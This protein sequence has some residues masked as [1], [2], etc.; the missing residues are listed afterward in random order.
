MAERLCIFCCHNFQREIAAAIAAE[1]W[2]DVVAV[3][4]PARCGRPPLSW[5]ELRALLPEVGAQVVVLGRACLAGL[6]EAPAGFPPVRLVPFGQCFHMVASAGQVD[7]AIAGGG[8]LITPG[9]L[10]DWRGRLAEMGFPAAASGE[11]FKDF[12]R[13][14]VLFD[15][16]VDP[17]A[18]VKLAELAE[19]VGLPTRR[20]A[21]GL[22]HT[23]L[24]LARL[25]LEWRLDEARR[26]CQ[27]RDR[28]HARELAD[29]VSAMDMLAR[30]ARSQH[31]DEAIAAVEEL[32]HMLFAPAVWHYLRVERDQPVNVAEVPAELLGPLLELATPWAWSPSG[33]GFLL[34]IAR[35]DRVL[36][37][38]A[39]DRLA[40]PE[41]RERYLNL[42]LAMT[43]VCALAIDNARIR[44]R[45]VEAEKM[46]SLAIMVAGV[47]HE[48]NTP[49]GV[50]LAAASTLQEQSR[51][52]DQRFAEHTMTQS[53]L[54]AYLDNTLA[55]A[56]LIRSNMERIGQLI[57]AFRQVA[58]EGHAQEKHRFRLRDCLDE[59]VASLAG[60][61]P[62]DRIAIGVRCDPDLE[63][64]SYRA[65]WVSIFTNLISNSVRHGFKGRDHG[66]IDIAARVEAGQL[67]LDYADDG[68]G[69]A[70]EAQARIFDPFYT[71]DLQHGMGLGM[72]LVY[73]LITHRLGG[74]IVC[75]G[76]PGQGAHFH[77]ETPL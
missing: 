47:A 58:V 20:H 32:F 59:V 13:E 44:K 46:A 12:A 42:A 54:R 63:I 11:F 23:R 7:E 66:Q 64:D 70:A 24:L 57:E 3:E 35:D 60:Q 29:H 30:L 17:E 48:I 25:V 52:L 71:T 6:A 49:I 34:R 40:F 53:D 18:G 72:H 33:Q 39:V 4:F 50:G 75:V 55:E 27:E 16:G 65:D 14:L 51:R 56:A 67:V 73:N 21:V 69:L 61:L 76:R 31:E 62:A 2:P 41:Y 74:A 15:T 22:D 36:G 43:G 45:L 38:V 8:Y 37:L 5:G 68:V 19:T 77:I 28:R 1:G 9:W 10:A 26:A